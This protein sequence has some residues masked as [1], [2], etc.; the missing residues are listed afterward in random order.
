MGKG[1]DMRSEQMSKSIIGGAVSSELS[2]SLTHWD[3][4]KATLIKLALDIQ[5]Y[6]FVF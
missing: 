2:S 3:H 5:S 6:L 4:M 1:S